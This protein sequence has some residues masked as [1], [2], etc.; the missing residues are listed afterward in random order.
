MK[1]GLFTLICLA[2][3]A[4]PAAAQGHE[5]CSAG[6]GKIVDD[7]LNTA[8]ALTLK[9]AGTVGDTSDYQRWFGTYSQLNAER[10]RASLKSVVTALRSGAVTVICEDGTEDG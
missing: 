3:L 7:A 5:G 8:K 1:G 9:A 10:V 4:S 6:Q 2:W